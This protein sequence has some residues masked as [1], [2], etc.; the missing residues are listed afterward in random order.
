MISKC[1]PLPLPI[2]LRAASKLLR[3]FFCLWLCWTFLGTSRAASGLDNLVP[4]QPFFNYNFPTAAGGFRVV[5]AFPNL[6]FRHPVRVVAAP[7]SIKLAV[8]GKEGH[9]WMF[10]NIGTTETKS[11]LLNITGRVQ[12]TDN[13]GLVGLAFHPEWGLAGSPNRG[14]FYVYYYYSPSPVAVA[15]NVIMPGYVRLSR[16]TLADGA[17][18]A[19]SASEQVLIQQWDRHDWHGG[20]QIQ[21]GLDG[22]LYVP[23]GDEGGN[24][25]VYN[26][27]QTRNK[28][29]TGGMLRIDVDQNPSRSHAIRRQPIPGG[30][31]PA[32]WPSSFTANYMIPNDNPWLATDGSL[33]EEFWAIGLRSPHT[34]IMDPVTGGFYVGDVGEQ[35]YEEVNLVEKGKNYQWPFREGNVAGPKAAPSP[36]VGT[37]TPPVYTYPHPAFAAGNPVNGNCVISGPVYRG[38]LLGS[39]VTGKLIF[40]D[41]E[42]GTIWSLPL[43]AAG[44]AAGTPQVLVV[45]NSFDYSA[46]F[47]VGLSSFGVD[48]NNE[49]LMT[50][51]AGYV[52][53]DPEGGGQVLTLSRTGVG[54]P[55]APATLSALGVFSNLA[56]LTPEPAFIPYEPI[57]PFFS[58]GASKKRWICLPNDGSANTAAEQ[59]NTAGTHW[60]F[61]TGTVIM[62][63]F[64]LP[65]DERPTAAASTVIKLE[66]RFMVRTTAG[67]WYG[68]TYRWRADQTDA[69]L[70]VAAGATRAL[71]ITGPTGTTRSQTWTFPSTTS[72]FSCHNP[73]AGVVLGLGT[74]RLNSSLLYPSTGRQANQLVTLSSLGLLTPGFSQASVVGAPRMVASRNYN[75]SLEQRAKAYLDANCAYCHRP[76]GT[77]SNFDLRYTTSV[78]SMGIVSAMPSKDFGITESR[79]VAPRNVTASVLHRRMNMVGGTGNLTQMPALGRAIIDTNGQLTVAEWIN[80]LDQNFWPGTNGL[81]TEFYNNTNWSGVPVLTRTDAQLNLSATGSPGTGVLADNF[82]VRWKGWL[83]TATG[84]APTPIN[85]DYRFTYKDNLKVRSTFLNSSKYDQ[86]L[87][88]TGTYTELLGSSGMPGTYVYFEADLLHNAAGSASAILQ[89]RTNGSTTWSTI[90]ATRFFQAGVA[91][92]FPVAGNDSLSVNRGASGAASVLQNDLGIGSALAPSTLSIVTPPKHGTAIVNTT[93]GA[94]VY[95]HNSTLGGLTDSVIYRVSN[96]AG[97]TSNRAELA[98]T[99]RSHPSIWLGNY[100]NASQL[101]DGSISGWNADPDNDHYPNLLEYAFNSNPMSPSVRPAVTLVHQGTNLV[102]TYTRAASASVSIVPQVSTS[103]TGWATDTQ[104]ALITTTTGLGQP[105]WQLTTPILTGAGQRRFA[106]LQVTLTE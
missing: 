47:H 100:F 33:L 59:I 38:S 87:G 2:S 23:T 105:I 3:R 102:L 16:F 40:A 92:P 77:F 22:Y 19:S 83:K 94:I 26:S 24:D 34:S 95:T 66:T 36:I 27:T 58:D 28:A 89:W 78:A 60:S 14:C 52:D 46:G 91:P 6:R 21:F 99:I 73:T 15:E 80:T 54:D 88:T 85:M 39:A 49:L 86:F 51:M 61:P 5:D 45:N 12:I 31:P 55:Q 11:E 37:S 72:C 104:G 44:A 56:T 4:T 50:K 65:L 43:T 53:N 35:K 10:D 57:E 69:D 82:T 42:L 1:T 70:V 63:H 9:I 30:T 90:P 48:H 97:N 20:G 74:M 96:A 18:Q 25:D 68:I 67:G 75:A 106:R 81:V 64:D 93:T 62:K 103:L 98:V 13:T 8:V 29:L 41:H 71:T 76:G 101:E 84:T 32:G 7:R 17:T 79:V